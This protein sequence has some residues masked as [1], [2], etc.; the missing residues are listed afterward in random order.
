[1]SN[2]INTESYETF[3]LHPKVLVFRNLLPDTDNLYEIMKESEKDANGKYLF[4][5]WTPWSTFG[6]YSQTKNEVDGETIEDRGP[7]Y[8]KEKFFLDTAQ[9]AYDFALREYVQRYSVEL[10]ED[11]RFSGASLSK[12]NQDIDR[13]KNK[14]TMQ[15]HTDFIESQKDMPGEKFFI[16][17]TM[18]I[19]DDYEG[20]DIEFF[21]DNKLI[22][23]K[24]K[25]GDILIFPSTQPY[26][27]GV[28]T[29]FNG[30]KF[31]V[32]NFVMHTYAGS[33]EWLDNQV[34]YG[35]YRWFKMEEERLEYEAPRNM[36]YQQEGNPIEYD[37]LKKTQG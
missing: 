4:R 23:H 31:F 24:P 28:K 34:K 27:H 26:F 15:Y 36:R 21:I 25:A 20:G 14:M 22:N 16:T 13:L 35:A 3:E 2:L 37:E 29:I 11:W 5:E 30:N 7:R 19:N 18:Y 12:Y 8:V 33:K 9:Q 10:P 32:R 6:T 17:C 1:M